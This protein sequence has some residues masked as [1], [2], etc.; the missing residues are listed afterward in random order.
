MGPHCQQGGPLPFSS[1]I[2]GRTL[3]TEETKRDGERGG[4]AGFDLQDPVSKQKGSSDPSQCQ[5]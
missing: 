1:L 4:L 3:Q 5:W 2:L